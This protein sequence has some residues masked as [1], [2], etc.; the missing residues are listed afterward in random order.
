MSALRQL[1]AY[2]QPT[3]PKPKLA[4]PRVTWVEKQI[5][6]SGAALIYS[7]LG[8]ISTRNLNAG[9]AVESAF[10]SIESNYVMENRHE[11]RRFIFA[12]RLPG[13]LLDA[14]GPLND[15][16][17]E[18]SIKS[19]NLVVDYENSQG[20]FCLIIS[21]GDLQDARRKLRSFD[22]QWWIVNSPRGGG[23]LNFDFELI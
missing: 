1:S 19:L 2:V 15:F 4:L 17:G 18:D 12:N 6:P 16:F 5:E 11:V 14:V 10:G 20:L 9:T 21:P 23:K 3:L 13:L 8:N 7:T 22:E